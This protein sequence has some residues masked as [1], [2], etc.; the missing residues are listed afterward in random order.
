MLHNYVKTREIVS[1]RIATNFVRRRVCGLVEIDDTAAHVIGNGALQRRTSAAHGSVL[2][3][4]HVQL[5][6]VLKQIMS[7]S[8]TQ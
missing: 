6:V 1:K 8:E 4:S 2:V 5:L 7:G 3:A